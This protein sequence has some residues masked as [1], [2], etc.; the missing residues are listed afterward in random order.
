VHPL[1]LVKNDPDDTFGI[2]PAVYRANGIPFVTV[3][4]YGGESLPTLDRIS[5]VVLFGGTMNVDQVEEY[6]FLIDVRELALAAVDDGVP[7]LGVCLGGQLL[8]RALGFAVPKA[9][10]REIGFEPMRSTTAASRDELAGVFDDGDHVFHWHEDMIEMPGNAELLATSDRVAV[11]AYRVGTTAWG[12][13]FH[14][15][16]DLP[17]IELWLRDMDSAELERGWGKTP[18]RIL[19]E[20]QTFLAVQQEKGQEVFLR[21]AKVAAAAS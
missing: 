14:F 9:P 11:Q 16:V 21:F 13:Q 8:A 10:V 20:A 1:L 7:L 12:F 3:D 2:A 4:A 5:G 19:D 18:R 15:E 17:E 6:P